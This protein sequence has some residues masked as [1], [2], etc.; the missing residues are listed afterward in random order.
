MLPFDLALRPGASTNATSLQNERGIAQCNLIR[1]K[2]GF[3]QKLAGCLRLTNTMFVG[4]ARFLFAWADLLGNAY[5]AVATNQRL[6]LYFE[7]QLYDISPI[8]TTSN[9]A[10]SAFV[11]SGTVAS[12]TITVTDAAFG[13]EVGAWIGVANAV[14]LPAHSTTPAVVIQG[15][16]QVTEVSGDTYQFVIPGPITPFGSSS[17]SKSVVAF[18]TTNGSPIVDITLGNYVFLNGQTL[19]VGV[20]TTVG[21]LTIAAGAHPVTV[22]AGPTYSITGPGNA[23]SG[24][25]ASENGGNVE[26]NYLLELPIETFTTGEFGEGPFG[27]GAF[28]TGSTG[29]APPDLVEW[30]L[31]KWG[32]NLVAAYKTSTIYQW[33][34]PIA[35]GNV[36]TAVS[37]APA[38]VNGLM[39]ASPEQQLIAWGIYSPSLGEQDPLLVGFCD[40]ANLNVWTASATNQAGTYRLSTGSLIVGGLWF[41]LIGLLWTDVDFWVMTYIGFPLVYGF[42]KVAPNCGLIGRRAAVALGTTVAWMSQNDFFVFQGGAV[43]AM[44]CPVRDF[45][46]NNIDRQYAAAVFAAP[47]TYGTEIGWWFPTIGSEGVCN[48][49]VKWN[50]VENLWD[51][52]YDTLE[53][54]AWVDQSPIGAP[55]GADYSGLLQQ[56]ETALDFDGVVF[57]SYVL[58][59][60]FQIAEGEEFIFMERILPDFKMNQG[61]QIQVTV[62]VAEDLAASV[63]T[64]GPYQVV[65]GQPFG[66]EGGVLLCDAGT[67]YFPVR[68]RGRVVRLLIESI[69]GNTF[70][71]VGKSLAVIQPDG[72]R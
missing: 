7:G 26:V 21:G 68:S 23:T 55:V 47:N 40:V 28:G 61:G 22:T 14:W 63:T 20:P 19:L 18:T 44:I 36:A 29:N 24:A 15:Y 51:F 17:G 16:Y 69:V 25:S 52:G 11:S 49:Y 65:A 9:L 41:G 59:G 58:T 50:V 31:D 2:N 3:I 72:R 32:Q 42:N 46:F 33:V 37:G 64:Y 30:S 66:Y 4:V 12:V 8:Q 13:P 57:D 10:P 27:A 62:Y 43:Q 45:V 6:Q 67:S 34:P 56:F 70:Y 39:T 35:A 48:A 54:S 1:H 60:W 38:N 71:R 5:L 53:L